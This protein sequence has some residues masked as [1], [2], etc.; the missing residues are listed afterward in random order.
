MLERKMQ[1]LLSKTEQERVSR[2]TVTTGLQ[3]ELD[4]L[5]LR[6]KNLEEQLIV[7]KE[8]LLSLEKDKENLQKQLELVTLRLPAP[9]EGFWSRVFRRK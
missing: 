5:N 4:L 7:H 9:K 6:N 1:E 2:L 3:H 8:V